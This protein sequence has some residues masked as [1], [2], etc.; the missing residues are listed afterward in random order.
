[1]LV[2]GQFLFYIVWKLLGLIVSHYDEKIKYLARLQYMRSSSAVSNN[3]NVCDVELMP[4]FQLDRFVSLANYSNW[5]YE[6]NGTGKQYCLGHTRVV[7]DGAVE[8][9]KEE[10][11]PFDPLLIVR[12]QTFVGGRESPLLPHS[13]MPNLSKPQ[14]VTASLLQSRTLD[15]MQRLFALYGF[16]QLVPVFV[17]QKVSIDRIVSVIMSHVLPVKAIETDFRNRLTQCCLAYASDTNSIAACELIQLLFNTI[18]QTENVSGVG[19]FGIGSFSIR[20]YMMFNLDYDENDVLF[21]QEV[22]LSECLAFFHALASGA[23]MPNGRLRNCVFPTAENCRLFFFQ[24]L[25]NKDRDFTQ[26]NID[27][28]WANRRVLENGHDRLYHVLQKKSETNDRLRLHGDDIGYLAVRNAI[29]NRRFSQFIEIGFDTLNSPLEIGEG[30]S[31]AVK[32]LVFA[33]D[34]GGSQGRNFSALPRPKVAQGIDVMLVA[35]LNVLSRLQCDDSHVYLL[36]LYIFASECSRVFYARSLKSINIQG[37]RAV[38]IEKVLSRDLGYITRYTPAFRAIEHDIKKLLFYNHKHD[39]FLSCESAIHSQPHR[40]IF[41]TDGHVCESLHQITNALKQSALSLRPVFI[42]SALNVTDASQEVMALLFSLMK[43]NDG[44]LT[45]TANNCF[46]LSDSFFQA[47]LSHAQTIY[48]AVEVAVRV[49]DLKSH[50]TVLNYVFYLDGL[51]KKI[52]VDLQDQPASSIKIRVDEHEVDVGTNFHL[53]R[54]L[55]SPSKK[56]TNRRS[57]D[58]EW[59][60]QDMP[61]QLGVSPVGKQSLTL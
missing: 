6:E 19:W 46:D 18:Y 61:L 55:F 25:M 48:E 56:T 23:T 34:V 12:H 11:K 16:I 28:W 7:V 57:Q 29:S 42:Q 32:H 30:T 45:L 35:C 47:L 15:A 53:K 20:Q 40:V 51:L 36:S 14:P 2:F 27:L 3:T 58:S 8:F 41:M 5:L 13:M 60:K 59:R 52:R 44:L 26:R 31:R 4:R 37:I 24:S 22:R 54:N 17:R 33:L 39:R 49:T 9:S 43:S 1:M 38:I 21:N 50:S 10:S